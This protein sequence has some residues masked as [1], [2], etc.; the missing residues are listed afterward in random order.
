V[1][2]GGTFSEMSRKEGDDKCWKLVIE[3]IMEIVTV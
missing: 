1:S 3:N 2:I